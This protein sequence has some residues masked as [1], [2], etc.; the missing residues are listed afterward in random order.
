M[1]LSVLAVVLL[2]AAIIAP[3][4]AQL[5]LPDGS[6]PSLAPV[7]ALP[8]ARI[9]QGP[10][11][12]DRIVAV[13]NDEP[14]SLRELE[15]RVGLALQNLRARG[16]NPMPSAQQIQ[17]DV[18]ESM[19][20]ERTQLQAAR[21]MNMRVGDS[22]LDATIGRIAESNGLTVNQLRDRI[23]QQ[24]VR[25]EEY[26][27][28]LRAEILLSMVREREVDAQVNVSEA[29]VSA[30]LADQ[31]AASGVPP[32]LALSQIFL[33]IPESASAAEQ[34]RIAG[35]LEALRARIMAGESFEQVAREGAG[36]EAGRGGRLG[37][38][39]EDRWPGLFTDAVRNLRTGEITP[40][41]R[42]GAGVH[43]LRL[44]ERRIGALPM[45][46]NTPVQQ[47]RAR[48]I[49]IRPNEVVSDDMARERIEQL[50]LRLVQG[51]EA[52]D[53]LARQHSAD[54]SAPQG[55]DLG[56]LSPGETVPSFEEAMNA[57]TIGQVSQPVRSPFGWHLI[58]V[59][60]RRMQD[61]SAE[62]L[63]LMARQAV[64]ER[65]IDL[66]YQ[67]WAQELRASAWVE[68]RLEDPR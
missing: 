2:S 68:L 46:D 22:Q 18:L 44:D 56:W 40:V 54:A 16:V 5:R 42:S 27:E 15:Q 24:G 57:L 14:I 36:E 39:P 10:A 37:A 23:E 60:E 45:V 6:R 31:Q 48:H 64:R 50:R 19:I 65:K 35:Q 26:R 58:V 67:E 66:A 32:E 8:P 41:I 21:R 7:D 29:E 49:L 33:P 55:G 63:R 9:Q 17:A 3:S 25:F 62:R 43:L 52:F 13:V 61:V 11:L 34:A 30:F 53:A 51:G 20:V 59:E 4:Q 28:D 38:R 47:T 1:K 12:V